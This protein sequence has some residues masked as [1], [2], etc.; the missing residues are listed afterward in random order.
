MLPFLMIH[1][2]KQDN[3]SNS[4]QVNSRMPTEVSTSKNIDYSGNYVDD[5]Y[6]KKNEGYDW[7]AVIVNKID[8]NSISVSVRSRADKKRP[9]CTFDTKA[10]KKNEGAYEAVYNGKNIRFRF[11]NDSISIAPENPEDDWVLSFFCSGGASFTGTYRKI[12]GELDKKQVDPTS[13]SK[14]LNLQGVGFNVSSLEKEEN[15]LSIFTFGLQEQ[16]YNES[17]N[18]TGESVINA[19]V[20]DLNSDGSPE[21]LVYTQSVESNRYGKVYAFSVNNMK[22]MSQVYF[23]PVSENSRI[24]KGYNGH[25]EFFVVENNLVQRFPVF[26]DE[27]SSGE[28]RQ[29]SYTLVDGEAMRKFEVDS[30]TDY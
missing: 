20:E 10:Y 6:V 5:G 8:D 28:T 14:V 22:S 19:E 25:D 12:D 23:P 17:F 27:D 11:S 1:S 9:T 13:F 21:L 15:M 4:E 24:N 3:K 26:N 30:I 2:C 16:E 7:I 29:V 18:I